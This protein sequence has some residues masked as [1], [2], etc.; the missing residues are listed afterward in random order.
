MLADPTQVLKV[1]IPVEQ[2]PINQD[3]LLTQQ[4]ILHLTLT[5]DQHRQHRQ[6]HHT[7]L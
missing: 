3:H 7:I 1:G 4:Q 6:R 2:Q 5:L